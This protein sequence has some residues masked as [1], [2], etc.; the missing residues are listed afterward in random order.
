MT[1]SSIS[2]ADFLSPEEAEEGRFLM[3]LKGVLREEIAARAA[4]GASQAQVAELA[5]MDPAQ[6]SRALS[7]DTHVSSRTLFRLAFALQRRWKVT[8]VP[9]AAAR[10]AGSNQPAAMPVGKTPAGSLSPS[11]AGSGVAPRPSPPV[12]GTTAQPRS[13]VTAA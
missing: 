6:L 2:S 9:L 1:C 5:G 11:F 8:L 13:W 3:D 12:A 4:A 7:P 10:A